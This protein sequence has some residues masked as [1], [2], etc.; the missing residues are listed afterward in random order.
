VAGT[1]CGGFEAEYPG[2][3]PFDRYTFELDWLKGLL[4]SGVAPLVDVI[5]WHPMY[6]VRPDDRYWIDYPEMVRDI[7]RIAASAG[8]T[9]EFLAEEILW[10][11][12]REPGEPGLPVSPT[13]A[14]KYYA[15]AVVMHRG[16]DVLVTSALWNIEVRTDPVHEVFEM[17]CTVMA[18]CRA[19]CMPVEI[20]TD[21]DGPVAYCT[22]RYADGDRML[23]VWT[24]GVAQDEDAG[25]PATIVFP[26][27]TAGGVVGIDVLYGFEQELAF[28]TE[29]G[30]T[31]VRDVLVRDY[32]VLIRLSDVELSPGYT[33]TIGDSFHRLGESDAK[34]PEKDR[35]TNRGSSGYED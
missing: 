9:G 25:V 6:C 5:S 16:L 31:V 1:V 11:R 2:H 27:L 18:E 8:F 35:S 32:P 29:G 19:V 34:E 12:H 14:G 33:E 23:A 10:K 22:F 30:S 3:G 20:V 28:R 4:V 7:K 24:D 26:G 15:R 13:V 17:L 21:S